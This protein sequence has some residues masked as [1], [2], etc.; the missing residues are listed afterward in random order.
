MALY[1]LDRQ[2]DRRQH[3]PWYFQIKVDVTSVRVLSPAVLSSLITTTQRAGALVSEVCTASERSPCHRSVSG[4]FCRLDL[5]L[6]VGGTLI[7]RRS[8]PALGVNCVRTV[9][10]VHCDQVPQ[11]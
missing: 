5:H 1:F 10:R 8:M 4:K 7:S 11:A 9:S 6:R 3:I 2:L